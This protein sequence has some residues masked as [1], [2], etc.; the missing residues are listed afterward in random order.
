MERYIGLDVHKQSCTMAVVGSSG[1]RLRSLV[2]ET[3]ATVLVEALRG[4]AGS[5]R[6]CMEEGTQCEW[7]YEALE[8]HV[9]ELA[10]I[11]PEKRCGSKNDAID[12]WD[13]AERIRT[14]K[15]TK[16]VV[17]SPLRFSML[18]E[19]VRAY[20]VTNRDVTRAKNRLNAL[21]RA[22]GIAITP[23]I[24]S[25][26]ADRETAFR[27]L[28]AP[29]RLRA[30]CLA[31]Q[32]DAMLPTRDRAENWLLEQAH[33]L[34]EVGRVM[35]AP[36]I[37]PIRAATIVAIVVNPERFRKKQQFWSYSGLGIVTHS[38]A[39]WQRDQ[40]RRWLR[41]QRAQPRGLNRNCNRCLKNVFKGAA[42][43]VIRMPEHPLRL[44]YDRMLENGIK[45]N[46]ARLTIAR[47]IASAVLAIW[48]HKEEY[49]PARHSSKAA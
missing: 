6:L 33:K 28:K 19:A 16:R 44:A 42:M 34:P 12:A 14:R 15:W 9:D 48:K 36:G 41:R 17:K 45:P 3:N 8:P 2:L 24:Y 35:S 5:R 11:Q 29:Q 32:L 7:L 22:R 40:N 23:H 30:E 27:K 21:F 43:H 38:S 4:I 46:L 18:R 39:D 13:L 37:G 10:V 31:A 25:S 1:R 49:D 20:D 47:R 26:P